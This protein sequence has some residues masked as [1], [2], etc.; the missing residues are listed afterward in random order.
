MSTRLRLPLWAEIAATILAALAISNLATIIFF[1][2]EGDLRLHHFNDEMLGE[3]IGE[4]AAALLSA[5]EGSRPELL[6]ALSRPSQ[7]YS[8]DQTPLVVETATRDA[9]TEVRIGSHLPKAMKSLVRAQNAEFGRIEEQKSAPGSDPHQATPEPPARMRVSIPIGDGRWLN[10]RI[11]IPQPPPLPWISLFSGGVAAVVLLLASI[12]IGR[13][14][15]VPLQRLS[16]AARAMR[17]GEPAPRVPETGP[18]AVRDAMRS[19]NAMSKRLMSTL[20]GQRAMMVAIAHDLR[21]PI[22]ALRLR[23]EF[24]DDEEAKSRLL[25]TLNEMQAMTEAV[26][27]AARTS[28]TGEAARA[29]DVTALAE[30]L[31]SDMAEIGGKVTFDGGDAVRCTCRANEVRRALRNLIENALRYGTSAKVHVVAHEST[32]EIVVEDNGPGIPPDNLERVFEP[33]ARL[34]ESRSLETGGYGL[35]LSI[36]RL[37]ARGHGGEVTLANMPAGGLRASIFL[38]LGD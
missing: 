2:T 19:F 24:V 32:A 23:A 18:S 26:L 29:V 27:D 22:A 38:P 3:R 36:A 11:R 25:D 15:A 34:E 20:D 7:H 28:H 12:W 16:E 6:K 4:S 35:C 8:I 33:F 17:R 13:R 14:V 21:T 30:S 31:A 37:I 5:P 1:Q 9:A 10:A